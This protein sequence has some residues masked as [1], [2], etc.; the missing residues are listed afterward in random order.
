M[1]IRKAWPILL[2]LATAAI[3]AGPVRAETADAGTV[4]ALAARGEAE[5]DGGNVDAGWAML[6]EAHEKAGTLPESD[7]D[8]ALPSLAMARAYLGW[9]DLEGALDHAASALATYDRLLPQDSPARLAATALY[10]DALARAGR[11]EEE[12]PL[13]EVI[14]S[15][16]R[17]RDFE[18]D[19]L[20]NGERDPKDH[21][22]MADA[23]FYH[24]MARGRL[25]GRTAIGPDFRLA[26]LYYQRGR[27][28]GETPRPN[29]V[30]SLY[31][32]AINAHDRRESWWA[33]HYMR[34]AIELDEA[35][36]VLNAR[37]R[38]DAKLVMMDALI[39]LERIE[40][41]RP[42][43]EEVLTWKRANLPPE[44]Q[45][46]ALRQYAVFLLFSENFAE[47]IATMREAIRLMESLPEPD[48]SRLGLYHEEL[49]NALVES[50]EPDAALAALDRAIELY[51]PILPDSDEKLKELL[52]RH[53]AMT[54]DGTDVAEFAAPLAVD[55]D[56][57]ALASDPAAL[58]KDLLTRYLTGDWQSALARRHARRSRRQGRI[59]ALRRR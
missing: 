49:S 19:R 22:A 12:I 17:K 24:G 40:E 3:G 16:E 23:L 56:L 54:A 34:S 45:P 4:A 6:V 1:Q 44:E 5:L 7:P 25:Y 21:I 35:A 30:M 52:R 9:G 26:A 36:G 15:I 41:A 51:R 53:A 20:R 27:L 32:E 38:I 57:P 11:L 13:R 47:G 2:L 33:E 28:P 48:A 58:R 18:A 46:D 29:H 42:F 14:L 55:D 39:R 37:Q 8:R 50:G 31:H 43:A 59:S 10:A